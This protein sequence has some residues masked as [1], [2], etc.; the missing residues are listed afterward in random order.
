MTCVKSSIRRGD[1][2]TSNSGSKEG[3]PREPILGEGMIEVVGGKKRREKAERARRHTE[4]LR[5]KKQKRKESK[6]KLQAPM[7][8]K[9]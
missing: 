2:P 4:H 6:A 1:K 9:K 7:K 5:E 3:H 8:K